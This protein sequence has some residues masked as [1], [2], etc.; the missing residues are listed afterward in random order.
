MI[1]SQLNITVIYTVIQ[2]VSFFK[3]ISFVLKCL[4]SLSHQHAYSN[5][6][7]VIHI[8]EA[9][10]ISSI[11]KASKICLLLSSFSFNTF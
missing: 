10:G 3:G 1:F 9:E 8:I 7:L 6:I 11:N 4:I 2:G 5:L